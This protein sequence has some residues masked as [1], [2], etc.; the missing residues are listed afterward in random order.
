MNGISG[1]SGMNI[2]IAIQSQIYVLYIVS[3]LHII[4]IILARRALSQNKE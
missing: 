2:L 3:S 1:A 4:G